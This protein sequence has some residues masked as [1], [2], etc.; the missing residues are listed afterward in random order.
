MNKLWLLPHEFLIRNNIHLRSF[1]IL[2]HTKRSRRIKKNLNQIL[3][4]RSQSV[5]FGSFL[6]IYLYISCAKSIE[7]FRGQFFIFRMILNAD[8]RMKKKRRI[9][10]QTEPYQVLRLLLCILWR[11]SNLNHAQSYVSAWFNIE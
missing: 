10:S 8:E 7:F 2:S 4:W 9:S 11:L 1:H 6:S 3:C 5:L